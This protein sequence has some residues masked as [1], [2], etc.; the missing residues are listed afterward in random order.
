MK[1]AVPTHDGLKIATDLGLAEAF[2]VITIK[3][4]EIVAEELRKNRLNTYFKKGKGPLALIEDCSVV[5]VNNVDVL[6]CE[7]IRENHMECITT[8]ENL[9]TNAILHYLEHEYRSESNTCC[10]P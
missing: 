4:E 6:F 2:L 10:C 5:L 8:E 3:A 1:I 9:I 7:L